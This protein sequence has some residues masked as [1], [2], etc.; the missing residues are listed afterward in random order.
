L[1][2]ADAAEGIVLA[3]EKYDKSEPVNLGT[4]QEVFI[5]DLVKNVAEATGFTGEIQWDTSKPEGQMRRCFD[6]SKAK[7]EFG[8]EAKTTLV[9]GINK[10]VEW[11]LN[12]R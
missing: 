1:Y 4:G 10:T 8:F 11:Y 12:A 2:V 9:D 3:T 5:K 7:E 6:V